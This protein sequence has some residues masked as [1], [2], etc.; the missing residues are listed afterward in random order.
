MKKTY[1]EWLNDFNEACGEKYIESVHFPTFRRTKKGIL[2]GYT[3]GKQYEINELRRDVAKAS[4][5]GY[6]CKF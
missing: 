6:Y 2:V 3:C 5:K 4:S 1:A